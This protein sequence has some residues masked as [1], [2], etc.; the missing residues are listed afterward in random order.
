MIIVVVEH[1]CNGRIV[2][3]MESASDSGGRE[4][5]VLIAVAMVEVE[6]QSW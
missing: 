3:E 1:G 5:V 2:V 6:G 4:M